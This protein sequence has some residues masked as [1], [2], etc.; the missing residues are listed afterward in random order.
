MGRLCE[1]L[2]QD[3]M[4]PKMEGKGRRGRPRM[5]RED[6]VKRSGKSG[7]RMETDRQKELETVDTGCSE[8]KV[9]KDKT[10]KKTTVT[11]A[12]SPTTIGMPRR[13]QS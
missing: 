5:R 12:T 1:K 8:R 11:M 13:E 4:P 3:H 6:C 2:Q 10:K 9:R 7:W